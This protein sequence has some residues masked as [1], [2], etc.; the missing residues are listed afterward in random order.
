MADNLQLL[1]PNLVQ[2]IEKCANNPILGKLLLHNDN[3][4]PL[5]KSEVY[6]SDIAPFGKSER[7]LPYPFDITFKDEE[8]T[9]LHIYYPEMAFVA[10]GNIEKATVWFD[11]VVHNRLWLYSQNG[12][13]LVRPYDIASQITKIFD[14]TIPDTKSTVGKLDFSVMA[15]VPVNEEFNAIRL[16]ALMTTF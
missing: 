16:Q 13:K 8:R 14:G 12:K 11:I 3:I 2:I 4:N 9:Q 10:S 5:S 7:I 1:S 15:H 6:P